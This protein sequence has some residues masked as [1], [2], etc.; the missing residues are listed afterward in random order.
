M[1]L[2]TPATGTARRFSGMTHRMPPTVR[3]GALAR[4]GTRRIQLGLLAPATVAQHNKHNRAHDQ[5]HHHAHQ[6]DHGDLRQRPR[7]GGFLQ[8]HDLI[9]HG[10]R[11]TGPIL[12]AAFRQLVGGGLAQRIHGLR[13]AQ[14]ILRIPGGDHHQFAVAGS[15]RQQHRVRL[16]AQRFKHA[17]RPFRRV[18][19]GAEAL[20]IQQTDRDTGLLLG[21]LDLV[22]DR[23][24]IRTK[25]IL[26]VGDVLRKRPLAL[27]EGARRYPQCAHE[28]YSQADKPFCRLRHANTGGSDHST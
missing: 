2:A 10:N 8:Q 24:N 3:P 25:Q 1:L 9:H 19:L 28:R 7:R 22:G 27:G 14:P 17:A 16:R 13:I 12:R 15:H 4:R 6:H 23:G 26:R 18:H 20:H 5:H 11:R 21:L